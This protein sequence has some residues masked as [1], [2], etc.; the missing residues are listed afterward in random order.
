MSFLKWFLIAMLVL[1]PVCGF[2]EEKKA[3]GIF[4]VVTSEGRCIIEGDITLPQAKA[5]ALNN[6]R[7]SALEEAVGVSLHGS[8]TLYNGELIGELINT[9]T[10]GLIVKQRVIED[11]CG[12]EGGKL[13]CMAK[14][15]AHVKPLEGN[16]ARTLKVLKASVQRFDKDTP[17]SVF[18]DNDEI[19]IRT[20]VNEDSFLNI[21]SVDQNGNVSMLYPNE[22]R[23]AEVIP[24][25]KEFVFPDSELRA[26]G[27]KLKVKTPKKL[28]KALESVLI[29][30]TKEEA[31]FLED[32]SVQ[33]PTIT[34]LMKEISELDESTS[35]AEKTVG[36]EVRK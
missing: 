9:A 21:F 16:R 1:A 2:A 30:A 22:F 11:R 27:L 3:E 12:D 10:K 18:Q 35:W 36:Y 25:R 15:E 5:L 23:K 6:A 32:A 4:K 19:Q 7:R 20:A 26:Q 29:I 17:A 13:C 24:K 8:S 33:N 14:I 34:D 28:S 31:H